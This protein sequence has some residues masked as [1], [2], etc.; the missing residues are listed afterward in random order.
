MPCTFQNFEKLWT[1]MWTNKPVVLKDGPKE[2]RMKRPT[3]LFPPFAD[4]TTFFIIVCQCLWTY[5]F[6]VLELDSGTDVTIVVGILAGT[7]GFILPLQLNSALSK[8][9]NC[10][11]N[12]N[13]FTGDLV[14]LCWDIIAF[15]KN[16][17]EQARNDKNIQRLFNVICAMPALAKHQFRGTLDLT[18]ATTIGDKVFISNLGGQ[19]VG[20]MVNSLQGDGMTVVD[21]CFYKLLDYLKDL[22][23]N[24]VKTRGFMIKSWE[25][26]YGSWG[27]MSNLNAYKP[28]SIFTN[29]LNV[30]LALYSLL[31]PFTLA[32]QGYHAIW[33]VAIIGY[34]F[35]GLNMA[36]R[37]VANAFAEN[38][39]GFQTVTTGQKSATNAVQ[40]VYATINR[41]VGDDINF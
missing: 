35:L 31:L 12:Y 8:N 24:D 7:L 9:A 26:A 36:G 38:A 20:T 10:L 11:N 15:Y 21:V 6:I 28:P 25:R 27:N 4:F 2:I 22:L 5:A 3:S 39:V 32:S 41:V 19:E 1:W 14:A 34:F 30:A 40:Q 37:K 16:D 23:P 33:M 13:A 17:P 18:K 29:V